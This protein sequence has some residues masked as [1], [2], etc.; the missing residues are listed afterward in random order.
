MVLVGAVVHGYTYSDYMMNRG[1]ATWPPIDKNN[2]ITSAISKIVNDRF[3]I[4]PD[5][6]GAHKRLHDL[7]TASPQDVTHNDMARDV[8]SSLPHLHEIRI[9]VLIL[10]GDADIADCTRML[11]SSKPAFPTPAELS[12]PTPATS[13]IW[14]SR[15]NSAAP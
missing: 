6:A 14:K 5:H 11:G 1:Q 2:A 15:K 3:L 7:L 12:F 8:S 9:P 10:V 13:C 4:A